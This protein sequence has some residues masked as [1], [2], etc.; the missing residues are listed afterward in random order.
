[1]KDTTKILLDEKDMPKQ[2]YNILADLPVPM[3][4]PISPATGKPLE[5]QELLQI[6]PMGLLQQEM[7]TER[8]IDIP[9][10]VQDIYKIWRPSP[11][12][13]ARRL[14]K[15][16]DTPAKIYFKNESVSPAGSHKLNTAVPQAYYNKVA[17][18]KKLSTETGAG[19]WGSAL[20][21]ACNYFGLDVHVY[22]VRASYDA[23][24]YR[25]LMME[26]WGGK[27]TPSPSNKTASGRAILAKDPKSPGSL[28]VAISEA[29]EEAAMNADTNYALGSVLNHVC[30]HQTVIGLEAQ[31][32]FE[33]IGEYPDIVIA[34]VGGGSNFAGLAFP[35]VKDK[36]AGKKVDIIAV[37]PSACPTITKGTFAYDYGDVAKLAPIVE[38]YTLGHGFM[39]PS[40]HAGGLRYHGMSPIVSLLAHEKLISAVARTQKS[41]FEAAVMFARS[42]GII[43][44][45]ESSHAIRV[46]IDEALK[47]KEEGKAKTIVFNLSGHGHFDMPS[48]DMYFNNHLEDYEYPSELVTAAL[49]DLPQIK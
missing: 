48:Y 27:V 17:G 20:S 46:A 21:L 16:L 2:W 33:M 42:E 22:Q 25:K 38:M 41:C 5:P 11:L 47:A 44:A 43:P 29:V 37:E 14:E 31:K 35:Y 15:L 23:K 12:V 19:Q 34:C 36:L 49:K 26:S 32:Q 4:P 28:G 45:P 40:I 13:R 6:F 39:P 7:S 9:E 10:E 1:M 24:P 8:Y 30:L 3:K 18:I